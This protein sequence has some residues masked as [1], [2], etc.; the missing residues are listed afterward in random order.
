[1][2]INGTLL[3]GVG[4][5]YTALGDDGAE[6]VLRAR[7]IF[8]RD[9]VTPIAGDRVEMTPGA[10]GADGWLERVLPRR[11]SFT[12]PAVA[13]LDVIA[14]VIA[15]IPKPDMLL[16]DK[17]LAAARAVN[18][19]P[20]LVV[21]KIDLDESIGGRVRA[22]YSLSCIRVEAVSAFDA[23][24]LEGP[25]NAMSGG[26]SCLAGQSGVGKTTLL[27][28]LTN[29]KLQAGEIS[30]RSERGRHTTRHSELIVS[31]SL[32]VLDTPGFS[33]LN[34]PPV[35]PETVREW[36][37]EF[38]P[39]EPLCR[40]QPCMHNTEPGCAVREALAGTDACARYERYLALLGE[41]RELWINRYR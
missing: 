32:R 6:Y 21:N 2:P 3:K 40:F 13:N 37:P 16:A 30:R 39:Y 20:I 35:P 23:E 17:L 41:V 29:R 26:V 38:E 15:P 19:K 9:G 12:R 34:R 18:V 24:S 25:R 10:Y 22:E 36:Y 1:M 27:S 5:F 4:G 33:L 7:G 14:V 11:N 31:D 8:R 28:A